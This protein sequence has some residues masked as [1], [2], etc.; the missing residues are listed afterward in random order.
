MGASG[1]GRP[2]LAVLY[3]IAVCLIVLA[4]VFAWPYIKDHI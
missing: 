1:G 2:Q 3:V 4:I